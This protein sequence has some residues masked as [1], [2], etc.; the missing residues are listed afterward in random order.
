MNAYQCGLKLRQ[1]K[2]VFHLIP[3]G[4]YRLPFSL[5]Q[6]KYNCQFHSPQEST[7]QTMLTA[8]VPRLPEALTAFGAKFSPIVLPS[9]ISTTPLSL[10]HTP[11]L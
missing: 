4:E 10:G 8:L 5:Q 1:K 2:L 3:F 6:A 7:S 11:H 9:V